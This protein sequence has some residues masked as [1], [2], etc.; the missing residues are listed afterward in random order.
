MRSSHV[1][2]AHKHLAP[3]HGAPE[4]WEKTSVTLTEKPHLKRPFQSISSNDVK[5]FIYFLPIGVIEYK[6]CLQAYIIVYLEMP[7]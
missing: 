3:P 4:I 6:F 7:K 1:P 5:Q 2:M